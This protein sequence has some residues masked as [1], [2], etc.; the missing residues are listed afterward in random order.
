M[1]LGMRVRMWA[2]EAPRHHVVITGVVV[3]ALFA[4]LAA[5]SIPSNKD[6]GATQLSQSRYPAGAAD[7]GQSDNT[8]SSTLTPNGSGGAAN[9]I[10]P[11]TTAGTPSGGSM[12][13]G[14]ARGPQPATSASTSPARGA[15][16]NVAPTASDVG[17]TKDS[18]K[19]GFL[20]PQFAGFDATGFALGFR[21]DLE[22][23]EKALVDNANREGGVHGRKI[24]LVTAKADPLSD[25]SMRAGCIK[26][27]Q[28]N[29]VFAVMDQTAT[30][31]P[32]LKCY[33]DQRTPNF[34]PDAGTV[35]TAFWKAAGGYLVSGG[36]TFDR[37]ILN[38]ASFQLD[39]GFIGPGKGKL[40]LLTADCEPDPATVDHVL[41]PFLTAKGV[42]FA[43]A[44]VSCDAGTAQQQVGAAA[45]QLRRA[46]VDRVLLLAL[47]TTSQSFVQVADAQ[48]WRPKYGV[49]DRQG[50]VLDAT[51]RA[52]PPD[53]FD[54]AR[55]VTYG[56]SGEEKAGVKYSAGVQRCSDIIKAAGLPAIT[57]QMGT[58]G[59]AVAACDGFFLWLAAARLA[60]VNLT[61]ADVVAAVPSVGDFSLSAFALRAR[62]GPGKYQG[63]DAY[64][65][66]EWR[67]SCTCFVQIKRPMPARY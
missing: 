6:R 11:A 39:E 1:T 41:K 22:Q 37:G 66:V 15:A 43:D 35:N 14:V 32:A 38:W 30:A 29:K 18:I 25:A 48:S 52:F 16:A 24:T 42:A 5:I 47:F 61:R 12:V 49:A 31:G 20:N 56:H 19:I 53:A 33:F 10:A 67:K 60:P 23:V 51:T 21:Q 44:R 36:S 7:T 65:I 9:D 3:L 57:N 55:G 40:G 26:M 62:Y 8:A 27:T 4:A 50:L 28:D 63:G 45:L 54:G 34:N 17:V 64:A 59:L 58:D 2:K 13:A 46:G